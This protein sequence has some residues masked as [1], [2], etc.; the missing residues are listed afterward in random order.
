[1]GVTGWVRCRCFEQGLAVSPPGP[2]RVGEHDELEASGADLR[3]W[4]RT[5]CRHP[6]MRVAELD[7]NWQAVRVL[8]GALE[9]CGDRDHFP[10][11]LESIPQWTG[12]WWFT[13]AAAETALAE[14]DGFAERCGPVEVDRLLLDGADSG[15][16]TARATPEW[17]ATCPPGLVGLSG[18]GTFCVW[19]STS[20]YEEPAFAA[21]RVGQYVRRGVTNEVVLT[22]LDHGGTHRLTGPLLG[23]PD[24]PPPK[25]LEVRVVAV[26]AVEAYPAMPAF[27]RLLRAAVELDHHALLG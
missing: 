6:G 4:T 21:A 9:R 26:P 23:T 24:R 25:R 12:S 18:Q 20:V 5:G 8:R 3:D 11:L 10:V 1:M 17:L 14:F 13:P 16:Q 22:D 27:Q 15:Y 2:V 19:S 7:L